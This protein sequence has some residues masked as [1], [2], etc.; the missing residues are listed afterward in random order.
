MYELDPVSPFCSQNAQPRSG[1]VKKAWP[2]FGQLN[3][4]LLDEDKDSSHMVPSVRACA[5]SWGKPHPW[6]VGGG[7]KQ[8]ARKG[9]WVH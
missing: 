9:S 6:G 2:M 8:A 4:G 5:S 3:T 1:E 7:R